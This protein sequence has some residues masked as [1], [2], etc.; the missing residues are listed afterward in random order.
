MHE[1]IEASSLASSLGVG[2]DGGRGF[3]RAL[4]AQVYRVAAAL[5][6]VVGRPRP[7]GRQLGKSVSRS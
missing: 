4:P 6:R 1:E 2:I 5:P 7:N 3:A